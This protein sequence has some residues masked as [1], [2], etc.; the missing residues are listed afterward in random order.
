MAMRRR[1][2]E[3]RAAPAMPGYV[4][5]AGE[6]FATFRR[7][8]DAVDAVPHCIGWLSGANGPEP[9]APPVVEDIRRREQKGEFDAS[10]RLGKY[11]APRWLRPKVKVRITAGP[12]RGVAGE[13][14]RITG[15]RM[16]PKVVI[17]IRMLGAPTLTECPIAAVDRAK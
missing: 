11:W 10:A 15:G 12:F 8:L 13:V 1:R 2:L 17:F 5:V 14:W 4:F 7:D 16:E 6:H 3:A 9:V